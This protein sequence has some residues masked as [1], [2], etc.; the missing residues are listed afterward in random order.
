MF[1]PRKPNCRNIST[2]V[3]PTRIID[4]DTIVCDWLP[5]DPVHVRLDQC[6][7][8]DGTLADTKAA[9]YLEK[10]Y[11]GKRL[12]AVLRTDVDGRGKPIPDDAGLITRIS[13][14]KTFNRFLAWLWESGEFEQESI[15][16][17]LIMLGY[18]TW[19]KPK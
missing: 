2:V 19:E 14:R 8:A 10:N 12:W 16:E 7:V 9:E 13:E 15:N 6:W 11:F 18:A 1:I 5:G 3:I 17:A 4:G